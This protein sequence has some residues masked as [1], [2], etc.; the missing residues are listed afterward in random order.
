MEGKGRRWGLARLYRWAG[1]VDGRG[2]ERAGEMGRFPCR[3]NGAAACRGSSTN[4]GRRK[5]RAGEEKE[6]KKAGAVLT[7][8]AGSAM[9]E[10]SD[11]CGRRKAERLRSGAEG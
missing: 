8:G 6:R 3:S 4:G 1:V 11:A 2:A 5:E 10:R 7:C 9:R